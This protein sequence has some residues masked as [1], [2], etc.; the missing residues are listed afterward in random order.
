VNGR[1]SVGKLIKL[2]CPVRRISYTPYDD[3]NHSAVVI[4]EN[5][6]N[7]P[8]F[9][10]HKLTA[11]TQKAVDGAYEANGHGAVTAGKLNQGMSLTLGGSLDNDFT[12]QSTRAITGGL[13]LQ[14]ANPS[15]RNKRHIRTAT[16]RA[17]ERRYIHGTGWE[18]NKVS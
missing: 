9:A 3:T 18:G 11:Q 15:L 16:T 6:H 12:A 17:I 4:F 10:E 2:E 8:A 13:T 14:E 1:L 7:H 5:L